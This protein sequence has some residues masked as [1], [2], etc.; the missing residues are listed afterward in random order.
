[1]IR[2]PSQLYSHPLVGQIFEHMV[3]MEAVKQRL[4][5]GEECD[6]WFYRNSSGSIEI[7]LLIESG[8][9]L[10][11]REIKSSS[12]YSEKMGSGLR[13]FSSLASNVEK[14]LVVYSGKTLCGVAV[15]FA[16]TAAWCA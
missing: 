9:R 3:V 11:P 5:C 2:D 15:N 13:A 8:A 6:L 12:T 4:N 7:D 16:D 10:Y 1:M 14:P